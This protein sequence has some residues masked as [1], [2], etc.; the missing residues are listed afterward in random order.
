MCTST[1]FVCIVVAM[2]FA[3]LADRVFHVYTNQV[4][5]SVFNVVLLSVSMDNTIVLPS[6]EVTV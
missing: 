4:L 5:L 2:P 1:F 6:E 3:V